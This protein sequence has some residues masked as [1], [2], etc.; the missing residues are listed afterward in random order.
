M[1]YV[2][3]TYFLNCFLAKITN[4]KDVLIRGAYI[5]NSNTGF[6]IEI[7]Q[8]YTIANRDS[9]TWADA[10]S[11]NIKCYLGPAW[12]GIVD[13]ALTIVEYTKTTD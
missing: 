2:C 1:F 6:T 12:N 3:W 5:I 7:G 10:K 8:Q 4:S 9:R 11:G 13:T